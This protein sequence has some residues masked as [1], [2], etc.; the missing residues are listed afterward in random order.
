MQRI[1]ENLRGVIFVNVSDIPFK[2]LKI[3]L[4]II[5]DSQL[6]YLWRWILG[7]II[8]GWDF[9]LNRRCPR[10]WGFTLMPAGMWWG[11]SNGVTWHRGGRGCRR[12]RGLK[13]SKTTNRLCPRSDTPS[14]LL[15]VMLSRLN[16]VIFVKF[17]KLRTRLT[18]AQRIVMH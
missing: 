5:L 18:L 14:L 9:V 3:L 15:L 16:F 7:W 10:H 11:A 4:H 6:L 2:F 8:I 1:V 12:V 17:R 13:K